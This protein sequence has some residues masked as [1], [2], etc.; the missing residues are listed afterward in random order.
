MY[1]MI[2]DKDTNFVYISNKLSLWKNY[3]TFCNELVSVM[4]ELKIP[5][6]K[7]YDAK[8]VW[9][10][11]FMPIQLE[12]NIFLKYQYA[13]DYL[14]R[15]EKRKS[16][17]TDCA[18]ACRKLGIQYQETDIVIDGGNVVLCGDNVIMTDKVFAENNTDKHDVD[19]HKQL[20]DIFGHKVIIIPWHATGELDDEEADVYGHAD[21]FIKYCGGNHILMGNHRDSDEEE[22]ILIRKVLEEN[23]YVVTEMLFTVQ[24]PRYD[25]NWAYINFLQVGNNIILPKFGINEDEQAKRF[26]QTA[27]PYCRVRQID[28]NAIAKDG[29]ALHCITWNI[30]KS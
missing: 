26:V 8:D 3:S 18:E 24:E 4:D 9:A 14:V 12:E 10:R 27:F 20:E 21:G 28:C 15:I 19:F 1:I 2:Q 22:A 29:G 11:D 7:I 23:G 13:P 16:Y 17:I 25:L 6:G 5:Y 30:K